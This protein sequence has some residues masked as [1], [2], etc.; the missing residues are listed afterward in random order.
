MNEKGF[1]A[2]LS[3]ATLL[4]T[5]CTQNMQYPETARE[6]V[7]DAYFRTEVDDPYRWLENDTTRRVADW[8]QKQN[9]L[10]YDYL[11]KIPFRNQFRER[12]ETLFNFDSQTVPRHTGKYYLYYKK[13]GLANQSILYIKESLDGEERVLLDPNQLS[14]DGTVA[15]S[16]TE[17][18]NDSKYLAY[19]IADAGSDWTT[20]HVLEIATGKQLPDK[21]AW[22]KFSGIAWHGDGFYYSAYSTPEAGKEL[23][24]INEFHKLYYHKLGDPQEKDQLVYE[25]PDAPLRN[26]YANTTEDE[27]YLFISETESTEGNSLYMKDLV[28]DGKI[29]KVADGFEYSYSLIGSIE[30]DAYFLTNDGAPCYR[31]IKINMKNPARSNW[32]EII[33][34]QQSVLQGVTMAG[35]NFVVQYM[36]DAASR[37]SIYDF[38]GKR[39]RDI[40]L[41]AFGTVGAVAGRNADSTFFYSFSSFTVPSVV[42]A[43]DVNTGTHRELFRPAFDFDFSKYVVEQKFYTSKD[44]TKVPMFIVHRADINKDGTNPTLLYG[45][46]GF[47]I[48]LTPWFSS[49]RLAWLE[50]GG[51][52]VVANLRGGGEYGDAWHLA[53]TKLAKQ[54]VFDDFI[55]AAEYLIAE[56]YTSTPYLA[57]QGGSNGGLLVG[58]VTN[59]RPDLFRVAIPQVGVM[60]ML[61]YQKFT[62]GWAW[63]G[64]YGTSDDSEQMF[65]YL[66]AYSPIH[67]VAEGENYPAVLVMTG[68]HDDRVVP[69]HSFKYIAELQYKQP[70]GRPKLIRIETRAGHG[71]GKP[72]A[73]TIAELADIY[74]FM[75]YN[76]GLTPKF[77][78]K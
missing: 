28:A 65:K 68:D 17:V 64:D 23:S 50:Q 71:A 54:N 55:A 9:A 51:V 58:A 25:M 12:I 57:I 21:I 73:L 43:C 47:N 53:G 10:T 59:Q 48:S 69:A 74:S 29:T 52:Y 20:I 13:A 30:D 77:K 60:D 26:V 24:N 35:G 1:L 70:A 40:D 72:T 49:S 7:K 38:A 31:L 3:V 27:R 76:M 15:L 6:D 44:G 62:I 4:G 67:N 56:K 61:R 46:G 66:Y 36:V 34:E 39:L 2:I 75:F 63:A 32:Q 33:P 78:E 42:Y 11:G 22:T 37:M 18:S 45:Y 8:V 14:A 5:A 16:G 41:G 19:K